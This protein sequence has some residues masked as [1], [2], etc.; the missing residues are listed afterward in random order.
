MLYSQ[1]YA[2]KVS[3]KGAIVR[4]YNKHNMKKNLLYIRDYIKSH[5]LCC[6]QNCPSLS[7]FLT[8]TEASNTHIVQ[9]C[10]HCI[11]NDTFANT[12]LSITLF[13]VF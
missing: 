2:D 11:K 8:T 4:Q 1:E 5:Y 3:M 9:R 6:T 10:F 12:H 13:Y 7:L